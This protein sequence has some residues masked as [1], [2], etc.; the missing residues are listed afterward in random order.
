MENIK[1]MQDHNKEQDSQPNGVLPQSEGTASQPKPS[2][3]P[4]LEATPKD[5]LLT[6][7]FQ[8]V[9]E[10]LADLERDDP[11]LAFQASRLVGIYRR[12]WESWRST[13]IFP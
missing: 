1:S 5:A 9:L 2:P 3:E 7:P 10:T 13:P 12:L 8:T 11:K 4:P 6:G